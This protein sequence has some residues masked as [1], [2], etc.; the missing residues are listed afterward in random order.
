MDSALFL[1]ATCR[2]RIWRGAGGSR[3][4]KENEISQ[5]FFLS[6]FFSSFFLVVV[7]F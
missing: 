2:W 3:Q 7:N 6:F 5:L 4:D 1:M